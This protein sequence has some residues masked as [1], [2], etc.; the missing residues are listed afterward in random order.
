MLVILGSFWIVLSTLALCDDVKNGRPRPAEDFI[1]GSDA[2]CPA[3]DIIQSPDA[4][5]SLVYKSTWRRLS[6]NG[7]TPSNTI[8]AILLSVP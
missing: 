6:L 3:E 2:P 5:P 7:D 1:Q 4:P 8:V